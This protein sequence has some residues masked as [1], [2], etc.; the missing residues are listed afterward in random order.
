MLPLLLVGI[1]D[2]SPTPESMVMLLKLLF[3]ALETSYLISLSVG[4]VSVIAILDCSSLLRSLSSSSQSLWC[5]PDSLFFDMSSWERMEL[6]EPCSWG[7]GF[8]G[9]SFNWALSI[10]IESELDWVG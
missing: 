8:S 10:E 5:F 6:D 9:V 3:L 7:S 2:W 1:D 4:S